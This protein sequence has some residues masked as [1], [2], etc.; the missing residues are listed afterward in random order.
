MESD[1]D[2]L[3]LARAADDLLSLSLLAKCLEVAALHL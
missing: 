1:V 3:S 2:D